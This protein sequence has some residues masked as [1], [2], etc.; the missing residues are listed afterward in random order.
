M[1][2]VDNTK[3]REF[4]N[5]CQELVSYWNAKQPDSGGKLKVTLEVYKRDSD[6]LVVRIDPLPPGTGRSGRMTILLISFNHEKQILEG[7]TPGLPLDNT[8]TVT[9]EHLQTTL[10]KFKP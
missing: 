9:L 1:K 2:N 4:Y 3:I 7:Y 5:S 10:E 8:T 6:E